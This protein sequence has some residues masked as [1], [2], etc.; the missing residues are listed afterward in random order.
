MLATGAALAA[1][2]LAGC[3]AR[4]HSL[5]ATAA[6][7]A[8]HP[9][10]KPAAN[11]AA[12]NQ[13]AAKQA[14][15]QTTWPERRAEPPG[16]TLALSRQAVDPVARTAYAMVSRTL[17]PIRGP[18]VLECINL[19]NGLV[20]KGPMFRAPNLALASGDLWIFGPSSPRAR[21]PKLPSVVVS[22]VDPRSLRV[23]RS[24][25][26]PGTVVAAYPLIHLAAGPGHSVWIGSVHAG[27]AAKMFRLDIRTG[28]VLATVRLPTNLVATDLATD[29]AH[30]HLYVSAA[31]MVGRGTE[32]NVILE[33]H[34]RSGRLVAEANRGLVTFSV[35]GSELTAV[36]GGVWASFRTGMLGITLHLRQPDLTMIAPPGPDIVR[37]PANGLFHWAMYAATSY[38]GG[39]LWLANQAGIVAC[40]NPRTGEPRAIERLHEDQLIFQLLAVDPAR[41]Q[42]YASDSRGLVVITPPAHC[43]RG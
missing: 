31:H 2:L 19:R 12:A 18:Y 21:S 26:L 42:M 15:P 30:E 14:E 41:R 20:A 5:R 8:G 35:T 22:Q 38:G 40:I 24:I 36:P 29:P 39:S 27:P 1:L 9:S 37:S 10:K 28:T 6:G 17:S 32:G 11:Q 25:R 23:I 13:A 43:W 34:A 33:Y 7:C 3:T 16:G 4:P